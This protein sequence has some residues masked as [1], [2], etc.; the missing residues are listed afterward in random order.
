MPENKKQ[1]EDKRRDLAKQNLEMAETQ[2][3]EIAAQILK[4]GDHYYCAECKSELPIHRDC[5]TCHIHIDWDRIM[6]EGR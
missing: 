4:K 6:A 1:G 5:P 3:P 2:N